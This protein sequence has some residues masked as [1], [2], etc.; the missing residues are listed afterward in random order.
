MIIDHKISKY[1]HEVRDHLTSEFLTY[2]KDNGNKITQNKRELAKKAVSCFILNTYTKYENKT[3]R[4]YF[5]LNSNHF[6]S[7]AIVNG[8]KTARKVSYNY[9]RSLL[10]FLD[11]NCY[12]TLEKGGVDKFTFKN[13]YYEILEST[14]TSCIFQRKLNELYDTVGDHPAEQLTN[15]IFLKNKKKEFVTFNTPSHVKEKKEYI[16]A[17]NKFSLENVVSG[18]DRVYDV[19]IYKVYNDSNFNRGARSFMKDSIQGLPKEERLKL[20][21]NGN[22]L[23]CYDYKAFEPSITYSISQEVMECEDPYQI[24]LDGFDDKL[25]RNLCKKALLIMLNAE[26]KQEAKEA[27]N[28]TIAK[29]HNLDKLFEDYKIPTK[30]IPSNI[31]MQKL[32]EKHHLISHR[33]YKGMGKE[34]MYVGSLINDYV[35]GSMMQ[36]HKVLVLSTHDDFMCDESYRE[37]LYNIMVEGYSYVTGVAENCRITKEQ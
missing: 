32:E 34:V 9:F 23:C 2:L 27:F 37:T 14:S 24:E 19:Q 20:K 12:I 6:A 18:R 8:R 22:K 28:Y 31:I 1:L 36:N 29:E 33:F 30:Y 25:L 21:V 3:N 13:G 5:T 15:V 17:Y 35:V 16:D 26:S 11:F 7:P 10:D 4:S